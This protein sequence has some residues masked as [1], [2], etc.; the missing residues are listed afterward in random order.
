[1]DYRCSQLFISTFPDALKSAI[2]L[3]LSMYQASQYVPSPRKLLHRAYN[4]LSSSSTF[5]FQYSFDVFPTIS[6]PQHAPATFPL[7]RMRRADKLS[8]LQDS[9]V[10]QSPERWCSS[11]ADREVA[12][13]RFSSV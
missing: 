10:M 12:V 1:M 7:P 11:S 5:P 6:S 13:P 9:K 3:P 8:T 4:F 2:L